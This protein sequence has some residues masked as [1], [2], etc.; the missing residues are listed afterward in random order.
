MYQERL[1]NKIK[2]TLATESTAIAGVRKVRAAGVFRA[3]S[4]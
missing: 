4:V 3:D 2:L 1:I